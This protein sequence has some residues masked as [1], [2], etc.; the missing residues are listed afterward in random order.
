VVEAV[1]EAGYAVAFTVRSGIVRQ[2]VDSYA[3]PRIEVGA[4]D[5][6]FKLRVQIATAGWPRS[7]R[8]R[9]LKV[10]LGEA[11]LTNPKGFRP[12]RYALN[13]EPERGGSSR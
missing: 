13:L 5:T 1:R 12:G 2:D 8:R 11:D 7:W 9:V 6:P 4:N 3:L 10:C